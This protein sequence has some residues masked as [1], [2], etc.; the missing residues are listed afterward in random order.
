MLTGATDGQPGELGDLSAVK[1]VRNTQHFIAGGAGTL[2][3]QKPSLG[4][5]TTC[6]LLET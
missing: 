3:Q 6:S 1:G 5:A 4:M 2:V